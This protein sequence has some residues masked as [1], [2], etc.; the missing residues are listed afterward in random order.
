MPVAFAPKELHASVALP[1]LSFAKTK[2]PVIVVSIVGPKFVVGKDEYW[3]V[4][5]ELFTEI[6]D[7]ETK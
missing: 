1:E 7:E 4:T 2:S 6:P 3:V 5:P